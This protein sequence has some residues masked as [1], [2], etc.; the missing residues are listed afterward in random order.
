VILLL[1]L[2]L[3]P[4]L[5]AQTGENVLLVVNGNSAIS[6]QVADYYR[7][8]RAIPASNVCSIS[9]T[10]DE[11]I[12]WDVY[13]R[14]IETPIANCLKKQSLVEKVLYLVT[15]M[16]MPLKVP[17]GGSGISSENASVD[18]EL[19]LL[20]ARLKGAKVQRA[21]GIANPFFM[22]RDAAFRHPQFPIYLVTRLAAY[23][24][25][26]I[27]GMIDRALAARNRGKFVI[28]MAGDND[29][30]GNNWLRDTAILLP[31]DRVLFDE[32]E[33]NVYGARDVIGYASWGSN[34][35]NRKQRWLKFQ[36]LPGAIATEFVST[37]ARTMR[38]PPDT[39]NYTTWQDTEHWFAGS[40]QGLSADFLH[41]GATGASGNV[42]E[43][44]L[45]GCARPNYVLPAYYEGRNLAESF[46]LGLA[47]LSWQGVIF[48]DP[49]CSLG[50]P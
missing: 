19:T 12:P 29:H 3:A 4:F 18:S 16:G 7:P 48:G 31:A 23:D 47:M 38:R 28:D 6:R 33:K 5:H 39:W 32:S 46:Y 43:P 34:D 41:E 36:W 11:E 22:K 25:N 9:T 1:L 8:R 45:A 49:L 37:N 24:W 20:Y 21:G 27:K 40:P 13:E 10:T 30:D 14:E 44:Y 35:A 17:G 2:A 26:D 50:K 15:T 42:Y